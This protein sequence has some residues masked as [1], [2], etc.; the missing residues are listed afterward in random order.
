MVAYTCQVAHQHVGTQRNGA[1]L[2][3]HNDFRCCVF[4][5]C[6]GSKTRALVSGRGCN[7][8][9]LAIVVI[10]MWDSEKWPGKTRSQARCVTWCDCLLYERLLPV[11]L[12]LAER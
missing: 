4:R 9:T 8:L 6:F 10:C 11:N 1:Y 3:S 2:L 12:L 7:F 5:S